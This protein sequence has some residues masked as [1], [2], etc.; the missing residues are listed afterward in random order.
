ML[1]LITSTSDSLI[2]YIKDD[3][4]RP[5]IP[6]EFRVDRG[7]YIAAIV[8]DNHPASMVCISL[9]D[10]VPTTVQELDKT[11]DTP[12]TVVFYTIWSYKPGSGAALLREAVKHIKQ[13]HPN[14]TKFVTLSPKTEMARRFHTKNG[15]V[16]LQENDSTINYQYAAV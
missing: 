5:E 12:T 1:H 10:F 6:K 3:P 13:A 14:V 4:V 15:A 16:I 8:E 2:D 7:R 9:H 11:V